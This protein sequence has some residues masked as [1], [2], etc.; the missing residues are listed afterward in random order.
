MDDLKIDFNGSARIN[1]TSRTSGRD[2]T[3]QKSLIVL[4]SAAG[5]DLLFPDK[6]TDLEKQC[7]G[8]TML[9]SN[10]AMHMCNFAALDALYFINAT[11]R[12]SMDAYDGLADLDLDILDYSAV[13]SIVKLGVTV[14]FPDGTATRTPTL[15]DTNG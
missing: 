5:T 2:T 11:D 3:C 13:R 8:A 1:L 12:L 6:G 4:V 10:N 15:L 9:D 7:V 14:R